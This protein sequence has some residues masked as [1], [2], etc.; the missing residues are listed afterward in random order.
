[1]K[2]MKYIVDQRR[3]LYSNVYDC[4]HVNG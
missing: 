2:I 4:V 1:M 3:Y